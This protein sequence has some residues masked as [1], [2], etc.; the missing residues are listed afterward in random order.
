MSKS[1]AVNAA[2]IPGTNEELRIAPIQE[3]LH[4]VN[5]NIMK[6]TN[7]LVSG[8]IDI[9]TSFIFN[10]NMMKEGMV[11]FGRCTQGSDSYQYN[12][13]F[14]LTKMKNAKVSKVPYYYKSFDFESIF[15]WSALGD[16][17]SISSGRME[18]VENGLFNQYKITATEHKYHP[19]TIGHSLGFNCRY[20]LTLKL[21]DNEDCAWSNWDGYMNRISVLGRWD[22]PY[23]TGDPASGYV[24]LYRTIKFDH[25]LKV[26]QYTKVAELQKIPKIKDQTTIETAVE[27]IE[28]I[29]NNVTLNNVIDGE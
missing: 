15:V 23:H 10:G 26:K 3:A 7:P 9:I 20:D 13:I 2:P 19:H 21:P 8:I 11:F 6:N 5:D 27:E 12:L 29:V 22:W 28:N 16:S 17:V 18:L 24:F 4:H 25:Q 1:T 14:L